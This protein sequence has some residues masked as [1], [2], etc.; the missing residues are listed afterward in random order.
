M[1]GARTAAQMV[2]WC[3]TLIVIRILSPE[4]YGLIAMAHVLIGFATLVNEL[5]LVPAL[6]QAKEM[7][8]ELIRRV[9]GYIL[10]T[11]LGLFLAVFLTAPLFASFFGFEALIPLVRVLGLQLLV[12]GVGAVPRALLR[13]E[14]RFRGISLLGV[15]ASAV[16]S[17]VSLLL[18][19]SGSGA[20]SLVGASLAMV[21]VESIGALC[22][23]R[24]WVTPDFR[25]GG[26][27]S[28]FSFGAWISG[29]RIAWHLG[30]SADDV[31]VGKLL[32]DGS[33]GLYSVARQLST[34]PMQKM[35]YILNQVLFPA[36]SRLAGSVDTARS[37]FLKSVGLASLVFFPLMWGMSAVG[38]DFTRIILGERWSDATLALQLIALTVPIQVIG[39]LLTPLTDAM[40]RPDVSFRN[41]LTLLTVIPL[42]VLLGAQWGVNG[43]AWALAAAHPIILVIMLRRSLIL[44]NCRW[45][46]FLETVSPA[47]VSA[48]IMFVAVRLSASQLMGAFDAAPR[49]AAAVALGTAVFVTA[50]FLLNR[51]ALA[52]LKTVV[53]SA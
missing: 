16:G 2:T 44:V 22:L 46:P 14:M 27:R 15:L 3:V 11:N 32:G 29:A 5:G 21:T 40:G 19:V 17:I 8:V 7:P 20:W 43:V 36:Y 31:I 38:P 39:Y 45:W 1:A 41:V 35:M 30:Q 51:Q 6:I 18:A 49:L 53:W 12:G 10:L 9:F 48:G 24:F 33:L 4:D 50:T 28:L 13:R 34:M 47:A 52:L 23:A 26:M 42:F 25:L 37:Y